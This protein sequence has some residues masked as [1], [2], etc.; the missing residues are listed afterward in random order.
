MKRFGIARLDGRSNAQVIIDLVQSVDPGFVFT[1]EAIGEALS[2]GTSRSYS[3][4]AVRSVVSS[5]YSKILR[6]CDRA[7]HSVP[8]VGYRV[9]LANDHNQLALSR[10]K[11]ADVQ[12][13]KGMET[14]QH[15]RWSELDENQRKLH[16]GT[17]LVV[18]ALYQQQQAMDRRLAKV[19]Q[20]IRGLKKE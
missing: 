12:M 2:A 8:K 1:Y 3:G 18:G 11:R 17:L 15:V 13:R 14:L 20:L 7:L 16:E 10:T 6:G 19:E 4:A 5:S 9:A